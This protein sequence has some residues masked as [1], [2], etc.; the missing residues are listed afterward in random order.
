MGRDWPCH[1]IDPFKWE[2][3]WWRKPCQVHPVYSYVWAGLFT[4]IQYCHSD[5]L[6]GA[7]FDMHERGEHLIFHLWEIKSILDIW[8][9]SQKFHKIVQS[10]CS[11]LK[12]KYLHLWQ[13][14]EDCWSGITCYDRK[15]LSLIHVWPVLLR[16]PYSSVNAQGPTLTSLW[17]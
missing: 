8:V 5:S 3:P 1:C 12:R 9:H 6:V 2:S 4:S 7:S 16:S 14:Y 13:N 11:I 10:G 15:W 17:K